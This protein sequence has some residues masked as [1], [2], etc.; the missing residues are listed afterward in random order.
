MNLGQL[1]TL[2]RDLIRD[3]VNYEATA[4]D[5]QSALNYSNTQVV[6]AINWAIKTYCDRTGATY[7]EANALL[8]AAGIA[9]I[10]TDSIRIIGVDYSGKALV[11]TDASTEE[12]KDDGWE[13]RTGTVTRR[14]LRWSGS[15]IKL[16]PILSVWAGGATNCQIQYIEMPDALSADANSVDSRIPE[17][18][19]EHLKYAAA[20][21]LLQMMNDEQNI[22]LADRFLQQFD[23]LIKEAR[24]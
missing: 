21:Y 13:D 12:M 15:Q 4:P 22:A 14:W 16:T 19:Q 23:A 1:K 11:Q 10:P 9:T 6:E 17:T 2:V 20:A 5:S 18:Q 7:L 3:N 24:R 8:S